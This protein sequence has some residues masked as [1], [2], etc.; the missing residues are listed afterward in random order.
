MLNFCAFQRERKINVIGTSNTDFIN[1]HILKVSLFPQSRGK[2]SACNESS[3][4]VQCLRGRRCRRAPQPHWARFSEVQMFT[5]AMNAVVCPKNSQFHGWR[6]KRSSGGYK[7]QLECYR[8]ARWEVGT[9]VWCSLPGECP[10]LGVKMCEMVMAAGIRTRGLELG[11]MWEKTQ[12]VG[13][14]HDPGT[15]DKHL[16]EKTDPVCGSYLPCWWCLCGW[17]F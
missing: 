1:K 13:K 7:E 5:K 12:S 4:H 10:S 6:I 8:T 16:P 9:S 14:R 17:Y 2:R 3:E 11:G 15:K